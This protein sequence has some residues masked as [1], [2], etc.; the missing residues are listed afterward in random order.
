MDPTVCLTLRVSFDAGG[1]VVSLEEEQRALGVGSS[2]GSNFGGAFGGAFGVPPRRWDFMGFYSDFMGFYS[3]FMK[4]YSD[5]MG[6][7]SD[8]MGY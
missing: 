8:L 2:L 1:F 7:Y 4:F 5:F 3:D 6:F